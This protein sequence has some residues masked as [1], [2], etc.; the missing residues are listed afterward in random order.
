MLEFGFFEIIDSF[1]NAIWS[2]FADA[3]VQFVR[4]TV[5]DFIHNLVGL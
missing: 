2:G 1:I 5:F 3:L 4:G